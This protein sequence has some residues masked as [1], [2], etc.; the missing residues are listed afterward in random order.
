MTHPIISTPKQ[1]DF[2]A[3]PGSPLAYWLT[4]GFKGIF[5]SK[6]S[7]GT[8]EESPALVCM[9]SSTK[10]DSRF[11]RYFWEIPLDIDR[12]VRFAKGGRYQKWIGLETHRVDWGFRGIRPKTRVLEKYPYL[13]NNYGWVIKYEEYHRAQGLTYSLMSRGAFGVR[14]IDD[15][16]SGHASHAIYPKNAPKEGL[17]AVLSNRC[18]SFLLRA[19][20][21]DIKFESGYVANLPV[22]EGISKFYSIGILCICLKAWIVSQDIVEE[23]FNEAAYQSASF[24]FYTHEIC[25]LLHLV[26][27]FLETKVTEAYDLAQPDIDLLTQETGTPAGWHPLISGYDDLPALPDGLDLPPL[28]QELHAYLAAHERR[29]PDAGEL[30]RIKANLRALYE[31]GPGAKDVLLEDDSPGD[32]DEREAGASGAHIPIPTETFLE[33]LSVKMQLHPISV[34]WLLEELRREGARCKPEELRL[35]HDRLSVLVL[36][37]LG[38]RWP[39]QVE[40]G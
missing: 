13:D 34:Y 16:I 9:G 10:E 5:A 39:R 31:A 35:L 18:T 20:T 4:S 38:H 2:L 23:S 29:S 32:D 27:G 14:T 22:V 21:Q 8:D 28:P 40:A 3:V 19:F 1:G 12:W 30:A 26:E 25:S 36:R 33:E 24:V 11:L 7:L 37:L 17:A 6:K 15:A